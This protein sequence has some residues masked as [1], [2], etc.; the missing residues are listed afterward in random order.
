MISRSVVVA[1]ASVALL[2]GPATPGTQVPG[3]TAM[4]SVAAVTSVAAPVAPVAPAAPV[5]VPNG[6]GF[7]RVKPRVAAAGYELRC[8]FGVARVIGLA[9]RG[10]GVSDHP[11]G[12]A[13]DFMVNRTTGDA[14]ARYVLANKARLGVTYVIWRQRISYGGGWKSM[15]NRGSATANHMDHVHVSF[16]RR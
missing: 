7:G 13:L 15:A 14:L 12:L 9:S 3:A 1:A 4:P 6:T 5:C 2:L 8:M 16:A 11:R 10:G